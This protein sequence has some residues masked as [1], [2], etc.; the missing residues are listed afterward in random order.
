MR[1]EPFEKYAEDYDAWFE[2][3]RWVYLSELEAVKKL[4]PEE[5]KRLE[6][7]VGTGRFAHLLGVEFGVEPAEKMGLIARKRGIKVVRAR[8]EELPFKDNSF[9]CVLLVVTLCFVDEPQKVLKEAKRVLVPGGTLIAGIVD[10]DSFLGRMYEKKKEK[11]RFYRYA[12]FY[13]AREVIE[14]FERE[15]FENI[16]VYQTVFHPPEEVKGI[17]P[18]RKGYGEGGFVVIG[19]LKF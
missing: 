8:G 5:G 6:V 7:G 10:K 3:Y 14:M 1:T 2:K 16:R 18:A 9:D 15:G 19:G 11:S 4:V 17:E 12:R 13:S